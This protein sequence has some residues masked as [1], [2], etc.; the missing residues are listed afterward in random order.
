MMSR[1]IYWYLLLYRLPG[2]E[3][4]KVDYSFSFVL[5]LEMHSHRR[6]ICKILLKT[7]WYSRLSAI[8]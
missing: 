5:K 3:I 2:I 6:N 1:E 4:L 7:W 8:Q